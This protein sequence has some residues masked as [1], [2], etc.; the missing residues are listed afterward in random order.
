VVVMK[1]PATGELKKCGAPTG[2]SMIADSY[3]AKGC[4][5]GYQTAGWVRMN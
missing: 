5:D 1:N 3:A 2:I 4:A